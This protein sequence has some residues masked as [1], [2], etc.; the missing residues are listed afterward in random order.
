MTG[1]LIVGLFIL[2]VAIAMTMVGKGGGNFYVVILTIANIPM[3]EAATTGQ[4]ILFSASVAA[5]IIFQ[6]NK[7]VSWALAM[8]VGTFTALSALAGGYLSHLFSGFS[9]KLIFAFMLLIA[10]VVMFIPVSENQNITANKHFGIIDIKSGGDI[11]HVNLLIA[12]PATI[13]TGF[14]SGMVGVSGGSFLVPLMVLACGVPMHTAVGTAS[15]LIAAT[16]FMG[17]I[18]HAIQGD[19]N[20]S[21][22]IP[23]AIITVV[24]GIL[25]G[26]LSLKTK[27]KHLKKLFAYTNWLAAL[28]MIINAIHTKGII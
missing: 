27:P 5:M 14:G 24:G 18:G 13:L 21:W 19:F 26:K 12:L 22:A 2:L 17:F 6:K 28:F 20:P 7:S 1:L 23:L 8:L 3:H 25:G 16:A 10:G 15:T 11:Y 4:F 9:L